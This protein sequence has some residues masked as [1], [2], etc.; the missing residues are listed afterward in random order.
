MVR[1]YDVFVDD[2][3]PGLEL[4]R[5]LNLSADFDRDLRTTGAWP[6][7]PA[8]PRWSLDHA[9]LT[10]LVPVLGAFLVCSVR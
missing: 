9:E 8:L 2:E 5:S 1:Y 3:R 10:D 4:A 6:K 7:E